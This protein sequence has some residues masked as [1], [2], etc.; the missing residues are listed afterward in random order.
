M[1]TT[2]PIVDK[3]VINKTAN[4]MVILVTFNPFDKSALGTIGLKNFA[5]ENTTPMN[6]IGEWIYQEPFNRVYTDTNNLSDKI[7]DDAAKLLG[8]TLK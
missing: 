7:R 1:E 4:T 5:T 2:F 3:K 8:V 6:M